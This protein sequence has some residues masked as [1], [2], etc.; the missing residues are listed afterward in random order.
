[1]LRHSGPAVMV[2]TKGDVVAG[3]HP[4]AGIGD[5]RHRDPGLGL[6]WG[7][8]QLCQARLPGWRGAGGARGPHPTALP[9][10]RTLLTELEAEAQRSCALLQ[11][12]RRFIT[13]SFHPTQVLGS[14]GHKTGRA[15]PS[16]ILSASPL[17]S[18]PGCHSVET[19][20]PPCPVPELEVEFATWS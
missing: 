16:L 17:A 9:R 18:G 5:L 13:P 19:K 14:A 2:A 8:P 1:M 3:T 11:S 10:C 4:K 20:T 6:V 15:W 12:T 7:N